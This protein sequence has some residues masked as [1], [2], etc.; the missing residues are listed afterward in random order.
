MAM[1]GSRSIQGRPGSRDPR[2]RGPRYA[3]GVTCRVLEVRP[4]RIELSAAQGG[5]GLISSWRRRAQQRTA[6]CLQVTTAGLVT[7]L[8][9]W[10]CRALTRRLTM[11]HP[12][13]SSAQQPGSAVRGRKFQLNMLFGRDERVLTHNL[14]ET[15]EN[16]LVRT[17]RGPR[18]RVLL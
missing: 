12:P 6:G 3:P 17:S 2:T 16:T 13:S 15:G 4:E 10:T 9:G 14:D 1:T 8:H 7:G 11:T 5:S 18:V